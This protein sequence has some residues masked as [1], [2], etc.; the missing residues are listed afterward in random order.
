[1][2][3]ILQRRLALGLTQ[4][5]L[6]RNARVSNGDVVSAEK[7]RPV[8]KSELSRIYSALEGKAVEGHTRFP[9]KDEAE[10]KLF[11]KIYLR[12]RGPLRDKPGPKH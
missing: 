4:R 5:Q 10:A 9:F 1:M 11:K 12:D 3:D 7:G 2:N 6:A 8:N